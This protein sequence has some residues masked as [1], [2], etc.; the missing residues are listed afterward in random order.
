MSNQ[1]IADTFVST[2]KDTKKTD[3]NAKPGIVSPPHFGDVGKAANDT[4]SKVNPPPS[5][6]L[7]VDA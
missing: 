4:F 2:V 7:D 3:T 1:S 5:Y 6:Q